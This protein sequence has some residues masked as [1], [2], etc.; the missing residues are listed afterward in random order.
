MTTKQSRL[1]DEKTADVAISSFETKDG[2]VQHP[3]LVPNSVEAREY[4]V[5]LAARAVRQNL[6]VVLPTGLGKTVIAVLTIAETLR[7]RKGSVLL[8]APTRPLSLQHTETLKR[9]LRDEGLIHHFSG[10]V[11]P[12]KRKSLWGKGI[13]IVATPQTIRNDLVEGRYDLS[14]VSLVIFDEAHRAVGDYAYVEIGRRLRQENPAARI[15]GLTAS[16]GSQRERIEEVARNLG[17]EAVEA[18]EHASADVSPYV[19]AVTP[20]EHYVELTPTLRSIQQEF[21]AILDEQE[22]KLR[23]SQVVHGQRHYG[24][25]KRELVQ[26][27]KGRGRGGT[28]GP[29]N[30]GVIQLAQKALYATICLEHLETQGLVP[31][32]RYLDRMAEKEDAKRMERSFLNDPRVQKVR[33]RLGRGIESSHPKVDVLIARLRALIE[34][35]PDALAIVFAQFRDT[36]TALQEALDAAG[37]RTGRLIGQQ[38]KGEEKGQKQDEQRD[39]LARFAR[40]EFNILLST[41]IG[42]EGLDVPEVD[43]VVFYEAVPSEIRAVQRRGRTGRNFAGQVLL[44][45]TK[46]T[47][48]EAFYRSQVAK[49]SKMKR[50]IGRFA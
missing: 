25:T 18:R 26:I 3:Y 35:R 40:R 36:V 16:P 19:H 1:G 13:L 50:L 46:D 22:A 31:L 6:L 30:F 39:A 17:V 24:V 23:Q 11:A 41:S 37:F 8:L 32:R 2:F 28:P 34:R 38:S 48:D 14:G 42:E 12:D 9:L 27:I 10:E 15:L 44:L 49:E 45:I 7:T 5:A 21:Q 29:P 4:Q 43:L 20:E 47:R 33:E